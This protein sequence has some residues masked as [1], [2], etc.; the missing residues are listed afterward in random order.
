MVS[1][2]S[3]GLQERGFPCVA[4]GSPRPSRG[5]ELGLLNHQKT[6]LSSHGVGSPLVRS[7]SLAEP[8]LSLLGRDPCSESKVIVWGAKGG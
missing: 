6:H 8:V 7:S 1:T 3:C 2:P 5:L 4:L